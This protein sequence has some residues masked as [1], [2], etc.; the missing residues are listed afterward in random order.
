MRIG[1]HLAGLGV[2]AALTLGAA[3]ADGAPRSVNAVTAVTLATPATDEAEGFVQS[4]IDK[5]Y[6]ILNDPSLNANERQSEFRVFL[7]SIMDTRRIA[8][9]TLG[10]HARDASD[11]DIDD[12]VDAYTNF[13][14]ALYQNNFEKFKG[15]IVRVTGATRRSDDD[16]IVHADVVGRDGV[17]KLTI[18]FRVRSGEAQKD[19][20]TDLQVEGVWL[21][22]NQRADFASYFQ[23]HGGML[24][25]LSSELEN[26]AQRIKQ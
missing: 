5:G 12:F 22:L 6:S 20:V 25:S 15:E 4:K 24:A 17:R 2:A 26:R 23:R 10:A 7:L 21:G 8:V 1:A 18:A 13:V 19:I 11:G 14:A 9:F 3:T 16:V